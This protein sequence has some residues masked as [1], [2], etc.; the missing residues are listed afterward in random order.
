M[1]FRFLK[2]VVMPAP[3]QLDLFARPEP[4]EPTQTEIE[5]IRREAR[6]LHDTAVSRQVRRFIREVVFKRPTGRKGK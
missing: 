1:R 6:N 5:S 4:R 3:K 2:G